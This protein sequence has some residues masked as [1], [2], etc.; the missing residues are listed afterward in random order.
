MQDISLL[1]FVLQIL[2]KTFSIVSTLFHEFYLAYLICISTQLVLRQHEKN[3]CLLTY[4]E[5]YVI[6]IP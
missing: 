1:N 2:P 6:Y 5:T 3:L 4:N